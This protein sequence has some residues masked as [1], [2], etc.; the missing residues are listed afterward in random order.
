MPAPEPAI[1]IAAHT[2]AAVR[3]LV[4]LA[5]PLARSQPPRE[6]VLV[7][8]VAP[9]A[10]VVVRGGLQTEG[11]LVADATRDVQRV[12]SELLDRH[13]E[14]RAV[15]FSS[16]D[17]GSS[18]SRLVEH[19]GA[20][21]VLLDGRRPL[22]GDGVPRGEVGAVLD[23]AVSDVAVLVAREDATL[24]LG[25]G[26]VV[27]VPF[28]G[29]DHDWAA[30][31]LGAW[32]ASATGSRLRLLGAAGDAAGGRDSGRLLANT[33]LLIQR[34]VGIAPEPV[35]AEPGRAGVLDAAAGAG[36]LVIGLSDRW[37]REGLGSTRAAIARSAA[38][39]VVF[40]RRGT[41]PG[42]LA[43]RSDVTRFTWSATLVGAHV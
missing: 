6:L 15:A 8:L 13:V 7:R 9:P 10:G 22:L 12:R 42:A 19:E 43:P 11:R 28:G 20:E 16:P 17:G 3:Q 23:S 36:L 25:P 30:L 29:H 33:S 24:A 38:A 32:L 2:R 4:T 40:V 31:E 37:R 21:L 41:R 18:L 14:A 35:L 5:E 34:F 27:L 26:S 39:P 1:L